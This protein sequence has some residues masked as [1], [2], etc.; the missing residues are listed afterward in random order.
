MQPVFKKIKYHLVHRCSWDWS[1]YVSICTA[2]MNDAPLPSL[3]STNNNS[4]MRVVRPRILESP[5]L[6]GGFESAAKASSS[7]LQL[8]RSSG[9]SS[10]PGSKSTSVF[11]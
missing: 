3:R 2:D 1:I 9:T 4:G 8:C 7:W 5:R 10:S 6:S 11:P